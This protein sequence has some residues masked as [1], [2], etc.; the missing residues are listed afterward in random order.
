M[1]E[2]AIITTCRTGPRSDTAAAVLKQAGFKD[3]YSLQGGMDAWKKY[4]SKE[5]S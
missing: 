5:G 3:V 1:K 4:H 2:K